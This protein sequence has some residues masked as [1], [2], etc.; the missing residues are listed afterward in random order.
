MIDETNEAECGSDLVGKFN[1][2]EVDEH[3]RETQLFPLSPAQG[4]IGVKGD[5]TTV[6]PKVYTNTEQ[7]I[8]DVEPK[9]EVT[10]GR[11]ND[12]TSE[13]KADILLEPK[14]DANA[15]SIVDAGAIDNI[16]ENNNDSNNNNSENNN[17]HCTALSHNGSGDGSSNISSHCREQQTL[18]QMKTIDSGNGFVSAS[19]LLAD[20]PF[21][22][23]ES[24]S[25][26]LD[27]SIK[28]SIRRNVVKTLDTLQ[29][30]KDH[31]FVPKLDNVW[32]EAYCPARI[33][34]YGGWT[35]TPPVCYEMGGSVVNM[36]ILVD[37]T[38]PI[39]AKARLTSQHSTIRLTLLE[40]NLSEK[41][42]LV[43]NM[44]QLMDFLN[45]L[46]Q[47]ALLK[48]CVIACGIL[49]SNRDLSEQL[50]EEFG[51]GLDIVSA[52][53]LPHGS[54]L[55]TSSIL[56]SAIC[57]V[58]WTATGR[59][60]DRSCLLHVVLAVEQLLTT[61]GGWQDQV[62]GLI[63]GLKRGFTKPGLP[64]RIRWEPLPIEET[65]QELIERHFVLIYTGKV[66][67]ARNIL[68]VV[69][70][71]WH[72]NC[73][74]MHDAFRRL[75]T[76]SMQMQGAVKMRDL[77]TMARLL[78]DYWQLKKKLAEGSEPPEVGQVIRAIEPLCL[79]YSLLGAGGG[80]FLVAITASPD[81]HLAIMHELT[82]KRQNQLGGVSV[83]R[84]TMDTRGI[85]VYRD[86]ASVR[87]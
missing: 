32:V 22:Q 7:K 78:S 51:G 54:G 68:D 17:V 10:L 9:T 12:V 84:V 59:L 11:E 87:I 63:G 18:Q 39:S 27:P 31:D 77:G 50:K 64:F 30:I 29:I 2:G 34:L 56:A 55:G 62:G 74:T 24:L 5:D 37:G 4:V 85:L 19:T 73:P 86:S 53:H 60:Y 79:G 40:R 80:G 66:R 69:L 8:D 35:D 23:K 83:H 58:V 49:K 45:P 38:H 33:D 67:L 57:A 52:S 14:T 43:E 6:T 82:A 1:I 25:G 13:P 20:L 72:S 28:E 16:R 71:R 76:G 46:G 75:H 42:I 47:G 41:I 15:E 44:Q 36:A 70:S 21:T 26:K 61:G 48:A 3:H 81:A 65:F